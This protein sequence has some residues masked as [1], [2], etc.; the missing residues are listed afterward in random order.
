MKRENAGSEQATQPESFNLE[1]FKAEILRLYGQHTD[2]AHIAGT[3][4]GTQGEG[5]SKEE[6]KLWETRRNELYTGLV[7]ET[8]LALKNYSDGAKVVAET[9]AVFF[10]YRGGKREFMGD[11]SVAL[12]LAR[13]WSDVAIEVAR[14]ARTEKGG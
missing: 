8:S 2:A 5:I 10:E 12:P 11:L 7:T 6:R 14:A 4:S 3:Y 9:E 13:F 1:A